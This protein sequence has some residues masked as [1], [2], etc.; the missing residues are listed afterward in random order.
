MTCAVSPK[1]SSQPATNFHDSITDDADSESR[2]HPC[3]PHC[4]RRN[5]SHLAKIFLPV[6]D[7]GLRPETPSALAFAEIISDC[8]EDGRDA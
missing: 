1:K 6:K 5:S 7:F 8:A 2:D 4:Y 3:N